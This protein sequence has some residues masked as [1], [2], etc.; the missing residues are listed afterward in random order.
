MREAEEYFDAART[1]HRSSRPRGRESALCPARRS[2]SVCQGHSSGSFCRRASLPRSEGRSR[3]SQFCR[4]Q[5]GGGISNNQRR[6]GV[7]SPLPTWMRPLFEEGRGGVG[8]LSPLPTWTRPLFEKGVG[9]LSL[10]RRS[11]S[12]DL[13]SLKMS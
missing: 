6:T 5:A 8:V 2:H 10:L 12:E 7:L 11:P 4:P 3:D 13:V 9:V 1:P